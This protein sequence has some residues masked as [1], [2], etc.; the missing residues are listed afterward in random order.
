MS[1]AFL[2]FSLIGLF[3]FLCFNLGTGQDLLPLLETVPITQFRCENRAYGYYAD[4]EANCQVFHVCSNGIKWSFL[5]P[6]QTV[7]N[8]NFLVC[9]Y[10][11]SV[12]CSQSE[13]LYSVN[14][15]F[16][17]TDKNFLEP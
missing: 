9:D 3:A 8:Q 17:R 5:C 7:F 16:G 14:D 12:D 10:P 13:Q 1:K 4:V 11:G 15:Y 2:K 6:N